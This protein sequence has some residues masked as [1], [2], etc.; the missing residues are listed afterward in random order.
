M[1]GYLYKTS[2]RPQESRKG[3]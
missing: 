2:V 1:Q 3:H